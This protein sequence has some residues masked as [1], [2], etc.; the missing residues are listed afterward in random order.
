[1][2]NYIEH[3]I[4][5]KF[6]DEYYA[7]NTEWTWF[8]E[9]V[10]ENFETEDIHS[11]NEFNDRHRHLQDV[12]L[13]FMK[14]IEVSEQ[15]ICSENVVVKDIFH[16]AR[17]GGG[18]NNVDTTIQAVK[19][20]Y[21]KLLLLIVWITKLENLSNNTDY[22]FDKR[23]LV[24]KNVWQIIKL[25]SLVLYTDELVEFCDEINV[26]GFQIIRDILYANLNR[27]FYESRIE[28][29]YENQD[30]LVSADAF[31]YQII[32]KEDG[33]TWQES[34]LLDMVETKIKDKAITPLM[35]G[36]G[37][38]V[39]DDSQW[40]LEVIGKMKSY[41]SNEIADFVLETV[42]YIMYNNVPSEKIVLK[43]C[44]L[45]V[46]WIQKHPEGYEFFCSSYE[47][48]SALFKDNALKGYVSNSSYVEM[49]QHFNCI[50]DIEVL[51]KCLADGVPLLKE[52]RKTIK[53]AIIL[54]YR[55]IDEISD[56]GHLMLYLEKRE[57]AKHINEDYFYKVAECFR[58]CIKDRYDLHVT[59]L[60]YEYM[61]FLL[62]IKNV[63]QNIAKKQIEAEIIYIQQ[64]W[65]LEYYEKAC[66]SLHCHS[67]EMKIPT[68]EVDKYNKSVLENPFVMS[69][70]C[71]MTKE[72]QI[73]DIMELTS[74]TPIVHMV[75]HIHLDK[76]FPI[77]DGGSINYSRH[78]IDELISEIVK[79]ILEKYGYRMLN[80]LDVDVYVKAIHQRY[81][82]N[83]MTYVS[84][85][86]SE[87]KIYKLI[88]EQAQ[89]KML[90]FPTQIGVG[91]VSQLFP[92]LEMKIREL[93]YLLGIVP[94]KE[95]TKEF[96]KY[97]DPSTL[98]RIMLKEAYEITDSFERV[99][100]LLFVYNFMYNGTSFNI[101]NELVH[102]REYIEEGGLKFA[103][104]TTLLSIYM[105]DFR[106]RCIREQI[107]AH[108]EL[109]D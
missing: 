28:F 59:S 53:E 50:N 16:V 11:W 80:I 77:K 26:D 99:S 100:D 7:K 15:N 1:M 17:F 66:E 19:S 81:R 56:I 23:F 96:M 52:Q 42:Q 45:L 38:R 18:K 29:L 5:V 40:S 76:V 58:S 105:I 82:Q 34:Y 64:L 92:L 32:V 4:K 36:G 33:L 43:H 68:A 67:Y 104:K 90:P 106:I 41:F 48:I 108:N 93:A 44:A 47:V 94:F 9:Y 103:F 75:S 39:P 51:K 24:Q 102:G 61:L 31:S 107:Q 97:K 101:R 98:L 30:K 72:G 57:I 95:D 54:E 74:E 88:S 63:N 85:F 14:I 65:Q 86:H 27:T 79:R 62:E 3:E 109:D 25:D 49:I 35:S 20:N 21:G 12:Y 6:L 84:M 89:Y 83:A 55:E 2:K 87:K 91:H 78:E 8:I 22:L 70:G 13:F 37:G 73:C 69:Y 71:M 60:F 46:E 10:E